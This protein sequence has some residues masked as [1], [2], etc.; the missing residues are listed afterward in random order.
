[1]YVYIL[2]FIILL[3]LFLV[4]KKKVIRLP[5]F[6]IICFFFSFVFPL[7]A[8]VLHLIA[9]IRGKS[10]PPNRCINYYQ[11]WL[12]SKFFMV[13]YN[14]IEGEPYE[15]DKCMFLFN[16]RTWGDFF[17]HRMLTDTA[18]AHV[19]KNLVALIFPLFWLFSRVDGS[20]LFFNNHN[21]KNKEKFSQ[22]LTESLENSQMRSFL[23]YPEGAR[24]T[25][26]KPHLLRRGMIYYSYKT[27]IPCQIV[28]TKGVKDVFNEF[29][30]TFAFNKTVDVL[31]GP[32]IK[33][34]DFETREDFYEE[35][36]EAFVVGWNK[37]FKTEW[38][39]SELTLDIH[40]PSKHLLKQKG[41]KK[42][43]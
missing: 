42:D 33:P 8:L 20:I 37:V 40:T 27:N 36:L 23:I 24:N 21:I 17:I 1:M 30:L 38:K 4:L 25:S 19:S 13:K 18:A 39:S 12:S 41:N 22:W 34:S 10:Y 35:I 16:H 3:A 11:Q 14:I 7:T 28:I 2:I 9:I 32:L 5:L 6:I 15:E 26:D 43:N 31:Y 29:E